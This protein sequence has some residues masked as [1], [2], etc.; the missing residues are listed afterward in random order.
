MK[1]TI[2]MKYWSLVW[3]SASIGAMIGA[4]ARKDYPFAMFFLLNCAIH[5]LCYNY[6]KKR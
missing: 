6:H 3:M 4:A 1:F 5:H 2:F